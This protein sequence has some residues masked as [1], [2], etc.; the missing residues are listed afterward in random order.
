MCDEHRKY[1]DT[2]CAFNTS[3]CAGVFGAAPR[4]DM[5]FAT[6]VA[7]SELGKERREALREDARCRRAGRIGW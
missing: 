2:H 6:V 4:M 5:T 7:G 3:D 1:K